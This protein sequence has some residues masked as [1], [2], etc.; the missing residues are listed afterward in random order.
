L[1]SS[2][3]SRQ[4]SQAAWLEGAVN[5]SILDHVRVYC[6]QKWLYLRRLMFIFCLGLQR[7]LITGQWWI[8]Q[9][10]SLHRIT[11]WKI[12]IH[13]VAAVHIKANTNDICQQGTTLWQ[14][15]LGR[16]ASR[17]FW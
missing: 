2:L 5:R 14:T 1:K 6:R 10:C 12:F 9:N 17:A 16:T 3:N 11:F 4:S 7:L 8:E 15:A 13:N